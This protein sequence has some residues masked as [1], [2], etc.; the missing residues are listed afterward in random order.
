MIRFIFNVMVQV[1]RVVQ[2]VQ[3]V[4]VVRVVRVVGIVCVATCT[5]NSACLAPRALRANV[6]TSYSI[7]QS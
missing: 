3:V 4:R 7:I 5:S 6:S 2:V 1:V